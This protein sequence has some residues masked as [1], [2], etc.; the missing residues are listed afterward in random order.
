M[1]T[2]ESDHGIEVTDSGETLRP[3]DFATLGEGIGEKFEEIQQQ[4]DAN[5]KSAAEKVNADVIKIDGVPDMTI[6]QLAKVVQHV[7]GLGESS[8]RI[9]EAATLMEIKES[10]ELKSQTTAFLMD[11]AGIQPYR[12]E[13][14]AGMV[15]VTFQLLSSEDVALVSQQCVRDSQQGRTSSSDE[16]MYFMYKMAMS[17]ESISLD[18][19]NQSVKAAYMKLKSLD[20]IDRNQVQLTKLD[21]LPRALYLTLVNSTLKSSVLSK[22]VSQQFLKFENDIESLIFLAT[23]EP[24]FFL[25]QST[26]GP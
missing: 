22:I 9:R 15:T 11:S 2:T 10:K 12:R 19:P 13:F 20:D 18:I 14:K 16:S 26:E 17:I 6:E 5:R 8:N 21:L 1:S 3:V 25:E 23:K 7:R 4:I 24:D